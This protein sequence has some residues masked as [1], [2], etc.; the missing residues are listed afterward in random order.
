MSKKNKAA[1]GSDNNFL[2]LLSYLCETADNRSHDLNRK[3]AEALGWKFCDYS[4]YSPKEL[5]L[6]AKKKKSIH[7]VSRGV[8]FLPDLTG[9]L[10]AAVGLS[11]EFGF[12]ATLGDLVADGLP[13]CVLC[14]STDPVITYTGISLAGKD[15]VGRLARAVTSAC[16]TARAAELEAASE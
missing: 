13:G 11:I 7:A 14:T 10:D 5:K 9:S 16:L 3:I 2:R 4:W 12:I 8:N 6:A 15:P 1:P